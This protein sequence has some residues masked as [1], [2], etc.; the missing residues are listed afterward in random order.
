MSCKGRFVDCDQ[1]LLLYQAPQL[2]EMLGA[3]DTNTVN[4]VK[5]VQTTG[6]VLITLFYSLIK[7]YNIQ[8]PIGITFKLNILIFRVQNGCGGVE[9]AGV[10]SGGKG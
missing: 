7:F 5:E 9:P 2:K 10:P 1:G 3:T 4:T 6:I 8:V